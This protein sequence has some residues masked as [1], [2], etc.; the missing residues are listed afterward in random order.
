MNI[1]VIGTGNMGSGLG[2][3]WAGKGHRVLFGSRDPQK[4]RALANS[5]GPNAMGSTVADA[6]KFGEAV[7][8]AVRWA[9]VP[10]TLKAA[11]SLRGK[12]LIDC[13]NPLTP[14]FM[15]LT[16]A[17][18]T[19][20]AEEVAK[21]APGARVVK[22]FN[23]VF[24]EIIHSNPRFGSQNVTTFYCGDDA[25]AKQTVAGLIN[26]MGFEPVD[27]GPLKNARYLEPLAG[28]MI[29]MAYSLGMGTN[30]AIK[31]LRR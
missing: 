8:L 4:A 21:M 28:L 12:V 10:E 26:D 6:A 3:L 16:V 2:K 19:S 22:A 18:T 27:A 11:G 29:Q 17:H 15:A 23:H 25:V 31:L 9:N 24:A 1:G 30:Q 5:I 14:D 13:T 20:G 7:L